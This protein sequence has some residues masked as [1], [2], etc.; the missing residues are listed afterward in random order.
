VRALHERL[1]SSFDPS[2]RLAPGREVLP[3]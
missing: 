3:S 2:G 1:K